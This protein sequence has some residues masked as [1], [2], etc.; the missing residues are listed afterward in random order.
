MKAF[1]FLPHDMV[2]TGRKDPIVF[3]IFLRVATKLIIPVNDGT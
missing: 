3:G 1:H 2:Y